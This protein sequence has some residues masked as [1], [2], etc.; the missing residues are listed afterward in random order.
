MHISRRRFLAAAGAGFFAL[1]GSI[2]AYSVMQKD[3]RVSHVKGHPDNSPF[4]NLTLETVIAFVAA[5][6]GRKLSIRDRKELVGQ[7]TFSVQE[8]NGWR[9]EYV[10]LAQYVD[11]EARKSGVASL[12]S[13]SSDQKDQ[14]V[15]SILAKS[16]YNRKSRLLALFFVDERMRRRM[17]HSTI[18]QLQRVYLNSGV[19]WR[20]RGYSSWPGVPG[21]PREYTRPGPLSVC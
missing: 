11:G 1:A 5:L 8:D 10:W 9:S 3:S 17:H 18:E 6:Y 13:A 16:A 12:M 14:I 21:D 7:L 4:D 20:H 19:P 15:F 2:A